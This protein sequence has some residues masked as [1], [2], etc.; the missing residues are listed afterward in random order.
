MSSTGA[1]TDQKIRID[2]IRIRIKIP[3]EYPNFFLSN[4]YNIFRTVEPPLKA[5]KPKKSMKQPRI[6]SGKE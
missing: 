4:I 3:N 5:R 1:R 2:R 6:V